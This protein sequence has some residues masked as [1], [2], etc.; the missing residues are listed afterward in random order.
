VFFQDASNRYYRSPQ[1]G[2]FAQDQWKA[3]NKLVVSAGIRFDNDGGLYEKYG[4][5]VNFAHQVL[6]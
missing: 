4:N 5:L 1:V 6:L 2:A 3:T